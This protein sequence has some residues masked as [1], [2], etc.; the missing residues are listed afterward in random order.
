MQPMSADK[1]KRASTE[2]HAHFQ[3]HS[4]DGQRFSQA[5][6]HWCR[7]A[8]PDLLPGAQRA[9]SSLESALETKVA[10]Q[11]AAGGVQNTSARGWLETACAHGDLL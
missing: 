11:S 6:C 2:A 9:T 3:P 4:T 10:E 7:Q 5:Y 8:F 1:L